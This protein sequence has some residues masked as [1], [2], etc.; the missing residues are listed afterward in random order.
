MIPAFDLYSKEVGEG[1]GY[2]RITSLAYEIRTSPENSVM[3]KNLLCQ[4]SSAKVPDLKFVPYGLDRQKNERTIRDIII[5]Q[6]IYLAE[7]VIVPVTSIT[8]NDK[9]EVET[10]IS[11]SLYIT[12]IEATRKSKEDG[13]Y[14]LLTTNANKAN[15]QRELDNILGKYYKKTTGKI[16]PIKSPGHRQAPSTSTHFSTYAAALL[17]SHPSTNKIPDRKRQSQLNNRPVTISFS[18]PSPTFNPYSQQFSA[19]YPPTPNQKFST[20]YQESPNLK[21]KLSNDTTS[22]VSFNTHHH[23]R[24]HY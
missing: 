5:Q 14:L 17:T 1:Q 4:V 7:M 21:R 3:L 15:A 8:K 6:N 20:N 13:R 11:R 10:I 12:G 23:H 9:E 19:G 2:D 22:I 16:G 24:I 18:S